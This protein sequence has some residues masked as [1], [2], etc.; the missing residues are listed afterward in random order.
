MYVATRRPGIDRLD[1]LSDIR[2]KACYIFNKAG[3]AVKWF[4][5]YRVL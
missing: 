5:L 4:H 1:A 3:P 2:V